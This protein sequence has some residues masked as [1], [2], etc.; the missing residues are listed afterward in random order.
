[1][2]NIAF[3]CYLCVCVFEK[4]DRDERSQQP[5]QQDTNNRKS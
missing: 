3:V 4:I 5:N 2:Y 1:M